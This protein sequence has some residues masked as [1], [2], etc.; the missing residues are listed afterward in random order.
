MLKKLFIW[1]ITATF[2]LVTSVIALNVYELYQARTAKAIPFWQKNN[3]NN[4]QKID[5]SRWQIV[6]AAYVSNSDSPLLLKE[7]NNTAP[8]VFNYA[9]VTLEHKLVLANYLSEMQKIDPRDH[10]KTEQL[11]YWVNLYNALTVQLI[12]THYPVDSIRSIASKDLGQLGKFI[13]PWDSVVATITGQPLTLNQIEHGI[14]RAIWQDPRIHYVLN[15]ASKG[16]PDLT[17]SAFSSE[18]SEQQLNLAAKRFINQKKAVH[19][20]NDKL[21]L[22]SIYQWF[23]QDFGDNESAL[24]AH[25]AMY[26]NDNLAHRL[27]HFSGDII[28]QYNWQ[29]NQPMPVKLTMKNTHK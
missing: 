9:A 23:Q 26:S 19:F 22:S 5:H 20:I 24:L 12:L 15:C 10:P 11:A 14:L 1:F 29:L 3:A 21:Y 16:C 8:S 17:K 2:L 28:Y 27:L 13:G 4:L 7:G 6:L 18:Q 25:L